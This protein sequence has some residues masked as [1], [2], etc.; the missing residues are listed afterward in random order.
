MFFSFI[1]HIIEMVNNGTNGC[2]LVCFYPLLMLALAFFPQV[3]LYIGDLIS[4]LYLLP[5]VIEKFM[6]RNRREKWLTL[7]EIGNW[8]CISLWVVSKDIFFNLNNQF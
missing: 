3:G 6:R 7:F 4:C 5:Q 1:K 8:T 2:L